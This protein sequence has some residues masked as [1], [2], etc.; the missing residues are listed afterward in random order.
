MNT[1]I[2]HSNRGALKLYMH[3]ARGLRKGDP[4]SVKP[5]GHGEWTH[6]KVS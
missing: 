3:G 6:Y 5:R 2:A 4:I 1:V